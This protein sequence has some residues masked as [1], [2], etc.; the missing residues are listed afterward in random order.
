MPCVIR[1]TSLANFGLRLAWSTEGE[2]NDCEG[3]LTARLSGGSMISGFGN[4]GSGGRERV[5]GRG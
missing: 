2:G 3:L 5:A 1:E 4:R